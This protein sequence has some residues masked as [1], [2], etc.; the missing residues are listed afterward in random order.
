MIGNFVDYG[1]MLYTRFVIGDPPRLRLQA[2]GAPQKH[3]QSAL[4]A[5]QAPYGGDLRIRGGI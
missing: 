1:R 3:R 4:R 5:A 2:V